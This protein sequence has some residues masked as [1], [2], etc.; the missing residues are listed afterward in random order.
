MTYNVFSGTL[1][2]AESD[3]SNQH[4]YGYITETKDG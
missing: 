3:E 4:K 1:N 2:P